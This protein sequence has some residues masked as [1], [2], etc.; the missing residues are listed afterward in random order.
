MG[1]LD[2]CLERIRKNYE[3]H[4]ELAHFRMIEEFWNLPFEDYISKK[5][6]FPSIKYPSAEEL[7]SYFD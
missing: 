6:K 7:R 3:A 4:K 2:K 5:I 1:E